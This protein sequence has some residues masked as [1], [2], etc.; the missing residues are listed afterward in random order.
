MGSGA[1]SEDINT[2]K[3]AVRGSNT[4]R[5]QQGA[6][7]RG[8]RGGRGH[9]TP[10]QVTRRSTRLISH[11]SDGNEQVKAGTD[12]DETNPFHALRMDDDEDGDTEEP[13]VMDEVQITQERPGQRSPRRPAVKR[14]EPEDS[15]VG[16]L[17]RP[18]T[19]GRSEPKESIETVARQED[20]TME[21]AGSGESSMINKEEPGMDRAAL[22]DDFRYANQSMKATRMIL[23]E[24]DRSD[25]N[26]KVEKGL[27]VTIEPWKEEDK[28]DRD[29]QGKE[30][31]EEYS[32]QMSEEEEWD[33]TFV[34][35]DSE[36]LVR[37]STMGSKET[38]T[39]MKEKTGKISLSTKVIKMVIKEDEAKDAQLSSKDET[40]DTPIKNNKTKT[41]LAKAQQQKE[42][43]AQ[44]VRE[45]QR[46]KK[47]I[48]TERAD[49][50]SEE[51]SVATI[52]Q[53][54]AKKG[55]NQTSPNRDF[56]Q[57]ME[58]VKLPVFKGTLP[59][60][61][62]FRYDLKLQ[63]PASEDAVA[64]L[65]QT[66]KA[67]WAQILETD[68][69]A[70]LVPW[71]EE[72]Q[73]ENPLLFSLQKFPTTLST[74]KKY[75]SRAQ[76]NSSGQTLYVSIL[77]AHDA[78]FSEIMENVR[79]WLMEKKFGLWKRQVQSETIK[80]IGYLLYSTRTLEPEYMKQVVE[81]AVNRDK[82]A[83]RLGGKL[84]LG[85][86]WRIIPMGKQGKIKE[87]DQVRALHVECPSEQFQ[88]TKAILS[89]IYSAD[90]KAF[91]GGIK[92]RLV[93]DIYG[94]ANPETRA[95]VLHLRAR[96]A[97][98]LSKV[99]VMTSYEIASLDYRFEDD[100][101][102]VASVRERLMLIGSQE[103]EYLPQFVNVT[104]QYNG[105]GTVFTFIPQLEAEARS[106]VASIIPI[107]RHEFGDGVKKFFKPEAWE[108]H[109]DTYWDPELRVAVT[110][111]DKRVEDIT[112]QDPEY[113]WEVER[114]GTEVTNLPKR[115]DPKDKSLYG[116]D[117]G[118]SVSTFHTGGASIQSRLEEAA[119][120]TTPLV[121]TST[122]PTI[123]PVQS[124]QR[125]SA[126]ISS[127]S[128]ITSTLDGTVE[129]RISSLELATEQTHRMMHDMMKMMEKLA[130]PQS[131]ARSSQQQQPM[132]VTT[133]TEQ[134][135]SNTSR[136]EALK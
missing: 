118:D 37:K 72:H 46:R 127:T 63:V 11:Q 64:T 82:R 56:R 55:Q 125:G 29:K 91:P 40:E 106:I 10:P 22:K 27:G 38:D 9:T 79:W 30:S 131:N 96:Q 107:F 123:T 16:S 90:A 18:A 70:A 110:P 95:K 5:K 65:I 88:I 114:A 98:F 102:F 94:V 84:E 136:G 87:E 28:K 25:S 54:N 41:N 14:T 117:D 130:K 12:A 35:T 120:A 51:D 108:M 1:T 121:H 44:L 13:E 71:A 132:E 73:K 104:T 57:A 23:N 58:G 89:D 122:A 31:D 19:R 100:E 20:M 101:G 47:N 124:T 8:G 34:N 81:K 68:K 99:L 15:S 129:T 115:P 4:A 49:A 128:S 119:K 76:P 26:A 53:S 83:L 50:D 113:Q 86:R 109:E 6:Q 3:Q 43:R 33:D 60:K 111:D 2:M 21:E 17:R 62:L 80:Q 48:N 67:F 77:M 32:A 74:L 59:R 133:T 61:F 85:F 66:A 93:P 116:D 45:K 52:H 24:S 42:A 75:F 103:R 134:Y 126:R 92:L 112:E 39:D 69:A 7:G 105:T 135:T 36:A 78:P 97:L